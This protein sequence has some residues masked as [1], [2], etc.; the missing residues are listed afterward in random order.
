MFYRSLLALGVLLSTSIA[1]FAASDPFDGSWKINDAKSSW[2]DGKFPPNMSLAIDL[3]I[4]GNTMKYHSIN[5]TRK[6]QARC[7]QSF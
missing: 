2:S 6:D 5:D 4:D 1:V 7:G 3:K